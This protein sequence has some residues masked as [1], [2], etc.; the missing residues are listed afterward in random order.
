[1]T[2]ISIPVSVQLTS[3]DHWDSL[4]ERRTVF[5]VVRY[6]FY[7]EDRSVG[8]PIRFGE[9]MGV[10]MKPKG[11]SFKRTT[12]ETTEIESVVSGKSIESFL[13]QR[14]ELNEIA[15]DL[16]SKV[17]VF[18]VFN[19]GAAVRAKVTEKF[20]KAFTLGE[21]IS[22]SNKVTTKETVT[23]ENEISEGI[24]EKVVSVPAYLRRET[25]IYL[26]YIDFLKVSYRRTRFGLR[27]IARSEPPVIDH[28]RHHNRIEVGQLV[29]TAL[30]WQ[31]IPKSSCF[32]FAKDHRTEV[33]DPLNILVCEPQ[34]PKTKKVGFPDVPTL[35]QIAHAAFP[36]KWI[37]RKSEQNEW[38]EE[39]LK[40]IE[41]EEVRNKPGWWERHRPWN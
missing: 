39:S 19:F 7:L 28:K 30:Y 16:L 26:S 5:G 15:T 38:T 3:E 4:D 29:A 34:H 2:Y 17:S 14:D 9:P 11:V 36:R 27:K 10:Y 33:A 41:F 22:R 6:H 18:S 35:Y 12:S 13:L 20:T 32:V 24:D 31:L 23:I 8:D 21:E 40:A 25:N 1:M 37:W